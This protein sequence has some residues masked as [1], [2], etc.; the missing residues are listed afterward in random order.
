M[1]PS[2]DT[3]RIIEAA[4][5]ARRRLERDLHDGAQQR[6]VLVSLILRRAQMLARGTVV[7]PLLTEAHEELK[8]GLADLRD[9]A[10]GLH[11]VALGEHGLA[12]AL[13]GLVARSPLPITLQVTRQRV[14]PAAEAAIY[15]TVAE[16]LTNVVK[17]A[18]A[19]LASVD[20]DVHDAT[21]VAEIADNGVGGAS[22][23]SGSGLRGLAD[24]LGALSGSLTVDS[25]RAGGTIIR[26]RVP[27]RPHVERAR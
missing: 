16:A 6:L 26:A 13:E 15:F 20:V 10:R 17:H 11:P 5:E 9:L 4:D 14:A 12:A 22:P 7:E 19:T 21:L 8:R 25:P 23:A 27:L 1:Y 24:R 2:G 18:R 3:M